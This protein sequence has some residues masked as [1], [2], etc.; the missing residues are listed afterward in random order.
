MKK[1][2][3]DFVQSTQQV[4]L[5]P[6]TN[7][8]RVFVEADSVSDGYHTMDQLYDHRCALFAAFAKVCGLPTYKTPPEDG[9]FIAGVILPSGQCGYHLPA[10]MHGAFVATVDT[11][12]WDGH[13]S[14]DALS[15]IMAFVGV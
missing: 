1:Y 7:R 3:L 12:E 8:V 14:Q 11:P 9:W 6:V 10:S 13:T 4:Q 2:T 5:D 15:R